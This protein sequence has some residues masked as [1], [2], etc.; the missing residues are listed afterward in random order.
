MLLS[1]SRIEKKE[2]IHFFEQ[3]VLLDDHVYTGDIQVTINVDYASPGIGIALVSDEGLSLS[4][5]GETY[6]FRIG[7]SDYSIVRRMGTKIDVLENGPVVN[8]K[9]F[10]EG[11]VLQI[12]KVSNRV[13]FYV[14]GKKIKDKYLPSEVNK[15]MVG[16][17]SSAGNT[18]NSIAI[19]SGVP[20]GWNVNMSNTNGGYIKFA[21]NKFTISNCADKAEIEQQ[22]ISLTADHEEDKSYYLKYELED[23]GT[24]NDI[25][26]YVFL[27]DDDRYVDEEK[28]IL[29]KNGRFIIKKD[30]KV[31]VKF[32]GTVGT[33]KNI[34]L[35]DREND[36]YVGTDYNIVETNGSAI[37]IKTKELK[38]IEFAGAIHSIPVY[39][40]GYEEKYGVVR[41]SERVYT[42]E[43]CSVKLGPE[44][45]YEYT[46]DLDSVGK[47]QM[48]IE[49]N[50]TSSMKELLIVDSVTIFE[51]VDAL[52]DKL[53]LYKKDG[54]IINAIEQNTKK[55]YVT[56]AIK[57]PII[58][59]GEDGEPFNLSSSYRYSLVDGIPNYEFTNIEREVFEP[60]NRIKLSNKPSSKL[61][62]IVVY[63]VYKNADTD[64]S[65]L[66]C[67]KDANIRDLSDY[68]NSYEVI[69][70]S[71]LYRVDKDN[72]VIVLTEGNDHTIYSQ[73]KEIV[74]D[75]LKEKS[76][77]IN[78]KHTLGCYEI[79]ISS[80]EN[81]TVYYDRA[82]NDYSSGI[83]NVNDY[84]V[85]N[86]TI[87]NDSYIVLRGR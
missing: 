35:T 20:E 59:T 74:V 60:I 70:E 13:Y 2:K 10:I 28:N 21:Q 33:V 31:N 67:S 53:I 17:Y 3:D 34:Q 65:K 79:D 55:Q 54:T 46:I 72:A 43:Q 26:P 42:P 51:N 6:L 47:N 9:P 69:S 4:E 78:Y 27:S 5:D 14:N 41:D 32:T 45:R 36:F 64:R 76:Y 80:D 30:C 85:L 66:M 57:S 58:V 19:A 62:T 82:S 56:A 29:D 87:K 11:L 40:L 81:T 37:K 18:I 16:Y 44:Y 71:K 25:V 61:D 52:V 86:T 83:V 38:R 48:I 15:F 7:H 50:G 23:D 68:C 77:A 1:N 75:Y 39:E 12:R 22:N 49:R 8:V 63:G 73:Y 24:C 84:K